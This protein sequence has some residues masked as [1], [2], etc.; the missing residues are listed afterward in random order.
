MRSPHPLERRFFILTKEKMNWLRAPTFD[1]DDHVVDL[2]TGINKD[3]EWA[4]F[5][6]SGRDMAAFKGSG[7]SIAIGGRPG[8]Y[9]GEYMAGKTILILG[10][11]ITDSSIIGQHVGAGMYGGRIYTRKN[12]SSQQLAPGA[13]LCSID[14]S[15]TGGYREARPMVRGG[16]RGQGEETLEEIQEDRPLQYQTLRRLLRQDNDRTT[17]GARPRGNASPIPGSP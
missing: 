16:V 4:Y 2:V 5:I 10:L 11:G 6:S 15:D 14:E 1:H 13:R 12:V 17:P 8:D 7:L 3:M 9:L